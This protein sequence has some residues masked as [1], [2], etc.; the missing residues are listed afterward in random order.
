MSTSIFNV[1]QK[2]AV[3]SGNLLPPPLLLPSWSTTATPPLPPPRPRPASSAA[4]NAT[5]AIV[6]V[7][8]FCS[9]RNAD[10]VHDPPLVA[11]RIAHVDKIVRPLANIGRWPRRLHVLGG[12]ERSPPHDEIVLSIGQRRLMASPSFHVR[13]GIEHSPPRGRGGVRRWTTT[14]QGGDRSWERR[15]LTTSRQPLC[16]DAE[17]WRNGGRERKVSS[18]N[19]AIVS[20]EGGASSLFFSL[21]ASTERHLVDPHAA[22]F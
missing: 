5:A 20:A 21:V 13:G 8:F 19:V 10:G 16:H 14:V 18:L 4:A 12:I 1:Q 3:V 15:R 17:L 6:M 7:S 11:D 9:L 22:I 2:T